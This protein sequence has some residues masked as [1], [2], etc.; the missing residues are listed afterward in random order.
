MVYCVTV[1]EWLTGMTRNHVGF[2]RAGS[3]PAGHASFSK[4]SH[5]KKNK[6]TNNS[7]SNSIAYFSFCD[8]FSVQVDGFQFGRCG[9][10]ACRD[11][12]FCIVDETDPSMSCS[13]QLR[14]RFRR[15][16][17]RTDRAKY[18]SQLDSSLAFSLSIAVD[19][20]VAKIIHDFLRQLYCASFP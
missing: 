7:F 11:R 9:P 8:F 17:S 10:S 14:L 6:L 1:P 16:P 3:N 20:K 5:R 2:A 12:G 4:I 15:C 18:S 13:L 19:S